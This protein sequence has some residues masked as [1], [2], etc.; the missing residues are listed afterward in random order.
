MFAGIVAA[1]A[2]RSEAVPFRERIGETM[3][4]YRFTIIV[5]GDNFN[6]VEFLF[7]FTLTGVWDEVTFG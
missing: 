2:D 7:T 6:P 3:G 5:A 1:G 4:K